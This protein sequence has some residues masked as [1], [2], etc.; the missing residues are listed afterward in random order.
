MPWMSDFG[1]TL[2]QLL[3]V[4]IALGIIKRLYAVISP[5]GFKKVIVSWWAKT[6]KNNRG[7]WTVVFLLFGIAMFWEIL[8]AAPLSV[9]VA[10][11][12]GGLALL[13]AVYVWT[14]MAD[15]MNLVA[16]RMDNTEFR[17]LALIAVVI[18]ARIFWALWTGY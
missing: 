11:A 8:G 14:G 18:L 12:F 6:L 10:A 17:I 16:S 9:I 1:F 3:L 13:G 15:G 4:L 2:E 7:A 5:Q